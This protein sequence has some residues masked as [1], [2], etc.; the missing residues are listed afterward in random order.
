MKFFVRNLLL[1]NTLGLL[2]CAASYTPYAADTAAK[3]RLRLGSGALFSALSSNLRPVVDGKCG[4]PVRLPQLRQY[5]LP[6]TGNR[7][8]RPS[9]SETGT[10]YPRAGMRGS[11]DALRSDSAE[12]QL[13]PGRYVF[14]LIGSLGPSMCGAVAV[15]DVDPNRQY[16]IEFRIDGVARKCYSST[17]R[18][19]KQDDSAQWRPYGTAS[20][21]TCAK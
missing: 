18:L 21:Q 2:G 13:A 11:T 5:V 1:C 12:L 20:A 4:E 16:E 14:S 17:T 6:P 15:I 9:A 8:G 7:T 3:V 10:T 19:D